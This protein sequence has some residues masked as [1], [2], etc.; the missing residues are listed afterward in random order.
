MIAAAQTYFAI[1]TRRAELHPPPIQQVTENPRDW[2]EID[3]VS[4]RYQ[5][6]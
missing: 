2:T 3:P 1:Q 5:G 6:W 4:G